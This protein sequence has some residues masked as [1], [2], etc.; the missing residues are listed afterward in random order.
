MTP[1]FWSTRL[2]FLLPF[3]WACLGAAQAGEVTT[4][5]PNEEM[6]ELYQGVAVFTDP[7]CQETISSIS[8]LDATRFEPL[9]RTFSAGYTRAAFW[10]RFTLQRESLAPVDWLLRILPPYLDDLRLF[11]PDGQDG[12]RERRAGDLLPFA[13]REIPY[14]GFVLKLALPDK[15]PRTYFLRLQTTSTSLAQF[16]LWLPSAFDTAMRTEYLLFG[17]FYGA[18]AMMLVNLLFFWRRFEDR[19]YLY[20]IASITASLLMALGINGFAAQFL[21]PGLPAL[22]DWLTSAGSSIA[23]ALIVLFFTTFLGIH[24]QKTRLFYLYWL[25]IAVSF[26]TLASTFTNFYIY[27]APMMFLLT[28]ML[29]PPTLFFSWRSMRT[30]QPGS[31]QIFWGY[32]LYASLITVNLLTVLGLLPADTL[33][34]YGW[35]YGM[36][37]YVF[38]MQYAVLAQLRR[39]ETDRTVALARATQS[40]AT[41]QQ[42]VSKRQQQSHYLALMTHELKTPLAVIDA[43]IQ[44][45]DYLQATPE[46]GVARRHAR[47]R[48]AVAQLNSLVE[49]ALAREVDGDAALTPRLAPVD[50]AQLV[51]DQIAAIADPAQRLQLDVPS[52][53][54]CTADRTLLR[55][56][57]GNQIE[58]ALK[59]APAGSLVHVGVRAGHR[60]GQIGTRFEVSNACADLPSEA[61][62]QVFEKYWRGPNSTG[63]EGIG[64]G[65]FL[66]RAIAR[67]H[68]GECEC[69][70][71][72]GCVHFSLWLP[73]PAP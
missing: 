18:I 3:F 71:S 60:N 28:L 33:L 23:N 19:S 21:F 34:L 36:A 2:L 39:W 70:I 6:R 51:S 64:L 49:N 66:V 43:A 46:P 9:Q 61:A 10:F 8:A 35:Q 40:E 17:L 67:A 72:K 22:T 50:V 55:I 68:G 41:A 57:L 16:S 63:K 47:V 58:N 29:I 62:S 5:K 20:F 25:T 26:L 52:G 30:G 27:I 31:Q 1:M 73:E 4:L 15:Q 65:L 45:L 11:E 54:V 69:A 42:E 38:F 37:T 59:Y 12:F 56:A 13:A 24:R 14:R 44:A 7:T 48:Q 32:L 53:T